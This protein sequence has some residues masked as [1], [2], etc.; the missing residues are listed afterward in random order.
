MKMRR[1]F[2][3]A[4]GQGWSSVALHLDPAGPGKAGFYLSLFFENRSP[5]VLFLS[6]AQ[7]GELLELALNK[8]TTD[9]ELWQ[10]V[11][12]IPIEPLPPSRSLSC[13]LR[14]LLSDFGGAIGEE[15]ARVPVIETPTS[16]YLGPDD[17]TLPMRTAG[18]SSGE[19]YP[20]QSD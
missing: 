14:S 9:Q 13:R 20:N 11:A 19:K 15:L 2:A 3:H 8:A 5:T 4:Q 16:D 7:L 10:A 12:K 17:P 6:P 1:S 18:P